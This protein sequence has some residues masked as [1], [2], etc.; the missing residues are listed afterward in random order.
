ME[1][2]TQEIWLKLEEGLQELM[3]SITLADLKVKTEEV[4]TEKGEGYMYYI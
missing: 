2:S 3:K 4:R 1:I